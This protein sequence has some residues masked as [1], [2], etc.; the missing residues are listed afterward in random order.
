MAARPRYDRS[1]AETIPT[2]RGVRGMAAET[3]P[4]AAER[5]NCQPHDAISA[6]VPYVRSSESG[7]AE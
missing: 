5:G 7:R 1:K 2:A 3:A 6:R 4:R